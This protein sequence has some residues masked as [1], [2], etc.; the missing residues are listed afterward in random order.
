MKKKYFL[1]SMLLFFISACNQPAKS[2]TQTLQQSNNTI[3]KMDSLEHFFNNDN[4]MKAAGADT[5]YYYFSRNNLTTK[6]YNYKMSKG[7]SANSLVSDIIISNDSIIWKQNDTIQLF[8]SAINNNKIE[9]TKLNSGLQTTPAV[10]FEKKD[11]QQIK[12]LHAGREFNLV[13]TLPVSTFLVR[14]HYDY[15]HGTR[16]AFSDTNFTIKKK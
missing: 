3:I 10:S 9:W 8:L 6:V 12:V 16:L 5:S 15:L 11:D 1:F 7:D 14:S 4:W 2:K 13:K